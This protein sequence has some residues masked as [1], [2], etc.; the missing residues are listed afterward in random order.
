M[1][2]SVLRRRTGL[3]CIAYVF[4]AMARRP[5]VTCRHIDGEGSPRGYQCDPD[6]RVPGINGPGGRAHLVARAPQR[7]Q[8]RRLAGFLPGR[9]DALVALR[10]GFAAAHQHQRRTDRRHERR[11]DDAGGLV[12][13]RRRRRPA[14]AGARAGADVLPLQV[15]DHHGTAGTPPGRR[16]AA[17]RG[18]TAVPAGLHVHPAAGGALHRFG[19]HQVHLRP[20]RAAG[21]DRLG[22]RT[23]RPRLRGLRRA[24]RHRDLRH[25]QRRWP[26]GDRPH[27]HRVRDDRGELGHERRAG[28]ALDAVG[29][30]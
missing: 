11:A 13:V 25:L 6:R 3:L 5:T 26:A 4:I 29:R 1:A 27:R 20:G 2:G 12:G 14:G 21:R 18:V 23:R 24:A 28:R 8:R 9:R 19:V 30:G 22:L 15:H 10:G 7:A 16:R 17:A